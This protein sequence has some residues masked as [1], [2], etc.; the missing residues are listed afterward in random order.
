MKKIEIVVGTFFLV[1]GLISELRPIVYRRK[2]IREWRKRQSESLVYQSKTTSFLLEI[3]KIRYRGIVRQE[4]DLS[5]GPCVFKGW[6]GNL[7]CCWIGGHRRFA[8]FWR[9]PELKAGDS[10]FVSFSNGEQLVYR[11]R[12]T[13][14]ISPT[15]NEEIER[16]NQMSDLVLFTCHP[17]AIPNNRRWLVICNRVEKRVE[18]RKI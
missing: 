12:E 13:R 18:R 6:P 16:I 15:N 10:V 17:P 1:I 3:P 4:E 7:D 8:D 11:V 14:L 9:L 2:E 5:R